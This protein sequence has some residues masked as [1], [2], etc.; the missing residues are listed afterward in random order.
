ML[1]HTIFR[2]TKS[3][4]PETPRLLAL[5]TRRSVEL[6]IVSLAV[7]ECRDAPPW[8]LRDLGR[9]LD[10]LL[11]QVANGILQA[12]FGLKSND[13]TARS[14]CPRGFA[15]VQSNGE[16][17]RIYL[18]PLPILIRDLQSQSIPVEAFRPLYVLD[19][20]PDYRY[21]SKQLGLL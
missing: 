1:V 5:A 17:V 10:T 11:L 21:A 9:H 13:G 19:W 2:L 3:F 15:P 12:A 4:A 7:L 18:S 16:P 6:E 8:V 14:P 20:H